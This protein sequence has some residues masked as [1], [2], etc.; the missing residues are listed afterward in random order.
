MTTHKVIAED[1]PVYR[2]IMDLVGIGNCEATRRIVYKDLMRH[3]QPATLVGIESNP[4]GE[5]RS[6]VFRHIAQ[7]YTFMS[8]S[9]LMD[10]EYQAQGYEVDLG[11]G[12]KLIVRFAEPMVGRGIV[13]PTSKESWLYL[14]FLYRNYRSRACPFKKVREFLKYLKTM[15]E[16]PTEKV[17]YRPHSIEQWNHFKCLDM[18]EYPNATTERLKRCYKKMWNA[19]PMELLDDLGNPYWEIPF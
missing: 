7:K 3:F 14:V 1:F 11:D 5:F 9:L 8:R 19:K 10:V 12:V 15:N 16:C 2:S 17:F 13:Q 6:E 18:V 4:N